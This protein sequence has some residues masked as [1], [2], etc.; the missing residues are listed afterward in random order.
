MNKLFSA[1]SLVDETCTSMNLSKPVSED[2]NLFSESIDFLIEQ[3]RILTFEKARLY[4]IISESGDNLILVDEAFSDY[5][6]TIRGYIDKVIA[7]FKKLFA[8]FWQKINSVI[9]RDKYISKHKSELDKFK[10]EMEFEIKGYAFAFSESV[11]NPFAIND[12]K[13][14]IQEIS[15]APANVEDLGKEYSYI[16]KAYNKIKDDTKYMDKIR[17]DILGVKY[18]IPEDE[19]QEELNGAFVSGMKEK[20]TIKVNKQCIDSALTFFEDSAKLQEQTKKQCDDIST[21]YS[22]ISKSLANIQK[23]K[24]DIISNIKVSDFV[25]PDTKKTIHSDKYIETVDLFINILAIRIDAISK[26]HIMAYSAKLEAIKQCFIQDKSI[27]YGAFK[28]VIGKSESSDLIF[29][30]DSLPDMEVL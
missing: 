27:L 4:S 9:L 19:W 6:K 21:A 18:S 10:P 20:A 24:D 8:K 17:K 22:E 7:F 13:D 26:A 15:K 3:D 29:G 11:P 2:I 16:I 12:I 23:I 5:I 28:E 14:I 1:F 30:I 25:D